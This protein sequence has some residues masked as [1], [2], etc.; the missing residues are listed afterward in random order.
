M[1]KAASIRHKYENFNHDVMCISGSEIIGPVN[2]MKKLKE[3][4]GTQHS[5]CFRL[6]VVKSKDVS[7]IGAKRKLRKH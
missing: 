5:V 1:Y 3:T 2:F 7:H 4:F 6:G